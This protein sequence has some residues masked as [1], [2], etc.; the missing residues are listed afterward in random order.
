MQSPKGLRNIIAFKLVAALVLFAVF[1]REI[2]FGERQSTA[3]SDPTPAEKTKATKEPQD[4]QDLSSGQKP[5][6]PAAELDKGTADGAPAKRKSFLDDLLNLPR[7]EPD[8]LKKE[9]LGRFL[10]LAE[11]KKQQLEGRLDLLKRRE[12]QLLKIEK[13][14]D[15]KLQ[16]LDDERRFF[17]QSLQKE[18]ELKGKRLDRLIELYA[19][20]EPRKAAPI[21]EKLDKDLVVEILKQVDKK[22]AKTILEAMETQKSVELTEYFGRIKSAREYDLL[23]EL[24][25]SLRK[26]FQDCKG[27]PP[28]SIE[29]AEKSAAPKPAG[30]EAAQNGAPPTVPA[31]NQTAT[32]PSETKPDNA[33]PNAAAPSVPET[34]PSEDKSPPKIASAEKADTAPTEKNS[35]DAATSSLPAAPPAGDAKPVAEAQPPTVAK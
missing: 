2:I 8:S 22:Q 16:K 15:D 30:N 29:E 27:L 6:S 7:L 26:E 3:A 12:D 19:K 17:S 28:E 10:T 32:G 21:L 11:K 31:N 13:S 25:L 18:K 9:S 1:K 35:K 23:K 24:N 34:K 5:T 4:K 20:M 33:I 14:I